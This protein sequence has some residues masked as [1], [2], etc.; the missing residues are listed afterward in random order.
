[1]MTEGNADWDIPNRR[2]TRKR[3]QTVS[4]NDTQD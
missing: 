1:M 4:L 3:G 2:L